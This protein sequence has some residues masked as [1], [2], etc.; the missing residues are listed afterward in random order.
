MCTVREG[1]PDDFSGGDTGYYSTK[2][3]LESELIK[4][5]KQ[6]SAAASVQSSGQQKPPLRP[7]H[8]K[9]PSAEGKGK[10]KVVFPPS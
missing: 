6:L 3:G 8:R 7:A 1:L 10:C 5:F 9:A 4:P 2:S